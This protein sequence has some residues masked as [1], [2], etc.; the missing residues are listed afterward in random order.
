MVNL[1]AQIY[2]IDNNL[3]QLQV[4]SLIKL[5]VNKETTVASR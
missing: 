1:Q 4:N 5:L 2:I 3:I